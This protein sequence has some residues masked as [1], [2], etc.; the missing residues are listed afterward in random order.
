ML[1]FALRHGERADRAPCVRP[2][3]LQFDPCLTEKGLVQAQESAQKISE[4]IPPNKSVHIVSSPF[5]R[6][7]ETASKI[8]L[9]YQRPVHIEEG[10]GEFLFAC[11]FDF[12]PMDRLNI[13]TQGA[14]YL[15]NELGVQIIENNHITRSKYPEGYHQGKLRIQNVW[16]QYLKTVRE[17]VCIVVS[18]LFVIETLTEV[19]AGIKVSLPEYGYCR[20]TAAVYDGTYSVSL[21]ADYSHTNQ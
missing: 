17:D 1:L 3:L 11:D 10:F 13:K 14:R 12:D 21:V 5:L 7:I 20:M 15:E 9:M 2:C 4:M 18:H 6:C 8:A 16:N 19:W